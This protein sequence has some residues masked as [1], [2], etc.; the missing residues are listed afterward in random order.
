MKFRS[1]LLTVLTFLALM[2]GALVQAQDDMGIDPCF[3]LAEADCTVINEASANGLGDATSFTVDVNI[4]FSGSE[5]SG[6]FD[7]LA[8]FGGEMDLGPIASINEATFTLDGTFDVAMDEAGETGSVAG[9]F[10]TSFSQDGGEVT[11]LAMDVVLLEDFAYIND[12]EGW[13][14]I[15]LE[16][17]SEI[18]GGDMFDMMGMEDGDMAE[19]DAM[20]AANP[21]GDMMNEDMLGSM[22][23]LLEIPGFVTYER[24]GD[25]FAFTVDFTALQILLTDDYEAIYEELILTASEVDPMM[26]FMIPTILTIFNEGNISIV[27]T[28]DSDANIVSAYDVDA[29][30]SLSL[31]MLT[32]EAT[33]S[34]ISLA[35]DIA[36]SNL[37]GVS[38]AEAPADA[39][40]A[41]DEV[42]A[43]IESMMPEPEMQ[44]TEESDG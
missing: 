20:D 8:A 40:D 31:A 16:R 27:Q 19:G 37:N 28:V 5:L 11:E 9:S 6:L 26:A 3:G 4:D 21:L 32:G 29:T 10:T 38:M 22:T 39:V 43:W 24:M 1:T 15:D 7:A 44:A 42:I 35:A 12:G 17:L 14:S 23:G 30:L 25:D 34:D 33:T 41:T 13:K 18:E 2:T 36:F